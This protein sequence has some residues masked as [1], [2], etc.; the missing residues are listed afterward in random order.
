VLA[1][2]IGSLRHGD[3]L[4]VAALDRVGRSLQHLLKTV[5]HIYD[6]LGA[7]VV[8]VREGVIDTTTAAGRLMMNIIGAFAEFERS[9]ISERVQL[10]MERRRSAGLPIGRP[11]VDVPMREIIDLIRNDPSMTVSRLA[12]IT[13]VSRRT[14]TRRINAAGGMAA[15]RGT[16]LT[17]TAG[18]VPA[19]PDE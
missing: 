16:T 14:L 9:L 12:R 15:L 17:N 1:E 19:D 10:G 13:G 2:A 7:H 5:A 18:I 4:L 11:M 6:D 3:V 8:S